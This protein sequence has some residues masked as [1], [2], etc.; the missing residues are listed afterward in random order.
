MDTSGRAAQF[1]KNGACRHRTIRAA[2]AP[3]LPTGLRTLT[4]QLIDGKAVAASVQDR[5]RLD[6]EQRLK[7]GLRAPALATVLVGADPAS[8]VYVRNK[9]LACEKIG[10]R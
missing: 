8:E 4:A 7:A 10:I 2:R 3:L 5:V 1:T 9:R 6:V